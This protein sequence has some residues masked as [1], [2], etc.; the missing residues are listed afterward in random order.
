MCAEIQQQW[1]ILATMMMIVCLVLLAACG[2]YPQ[3]TVTLLST[4]QAGPTPAELPAFLSHVEPKPGAQV[5]EGVLS[6]SG[7]WAIL[8]LEEIAE[9]GETLG[10]EEMQERVEFLMDGEVLDAE[11]KRGRKPGAAEVEIVGNFDLSAGEHEATVRVRRTSGEVLE[12]S[13][14]F[15]ILDVETTM[16]DLPEGFRFVRP[17][18]DS[19]ITLQAYREEQLVPFYQAPAFADL[20]GGVCVGVLTIEIV[21]TGENLDCAS[22][23]RKYPFVA[24]DGVPP[25]KY[26]WIEER[27]AGEIVIV[28]ENGVRTT[29]PG[30]HYKCWKIELSPGEHEA[31]IELRKA[32]GE[33]IEYTWRFTITSD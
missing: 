11:V 6:G 33:V 9:P 20:R 31:T 25:G 13:W 2:Q 22:L 4:P 29:G 18:P 10:V 14:T 16:P 15:T 7:V 23:S 24:L 26:A 5:L 19:T 12:Y 27:C 17:L 3:S 8:Q 32:S 1:F 21:E 28:T 30:S